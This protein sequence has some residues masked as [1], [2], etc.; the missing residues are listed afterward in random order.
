MTN[1]NEKSMD[2]NATQNGS[3]MRT[4]SDQNSHFQFYKENRTS[5]SGKGSSMQKGG[6][7]RQRSGIMAGSMR[8]FSRSKANNSN[9]KSNSMLNDTDFGIGLGLAHAPLNV[10]YEDEFDEREEEEDKDDSLWQNSDDSMINLRGLG[11]GY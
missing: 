9:T 8:S 1:A 2:F 6:S 4:V 5:S 10:V 3:I 11:S 7:S